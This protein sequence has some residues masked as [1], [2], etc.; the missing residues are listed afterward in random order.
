MTDAFPLRNAGQSNRIGRA[1]RDVA[2]RMRMQSSAPLKGFGDLILPVV[3]V[4]SPM[5]SDTERD[6]FVGGGTLSVP[7]QYNGVGLVCNVDTLVFAAIP[8]DTADY[9]IYTDNAVGFDPLFANQTNRQADVRPFDRVGR[10]IVRSGTSGSTKG[11]GAR[12]GPQGIPLLVGGE[13]PLYCAAGV[14]LVLQNAT[15][16]QGASISYAWSELE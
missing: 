4:A 11:A 15:F 7:N 12:S 9:W 2:E 1:F 16:G 10:N 8:A 3:Q 14:T 5:F 6:F 13:R